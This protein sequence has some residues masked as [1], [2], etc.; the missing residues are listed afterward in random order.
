MRTMTRWI[1][2]GLLLGATSSWAQI[3][4]PPWGSWLKELLNEYEKC[5]LAGNEAHPTACNVFLGR[6]LE[7]VYGVKDF[8]REGVPTAYLTANEIADAVLISPKWERIGNASEAVALDQ[9]GTD[10]NQN[11]AVVAVWKNPDGH[12]HVAI[13]LPGPFTETSWGK[14]VPNSASFFLSRPKSESYIGLPLSRAFKKDI[15]QQVLLYRYR[16]G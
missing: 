8:H 16:G 3:L 13:V 14:K 12:G 15:R 5:D 6:A 9:A 10:A 4:I 11:V 7:K 1:L 2:V